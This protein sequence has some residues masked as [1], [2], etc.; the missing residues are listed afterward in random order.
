M[1]SSRF[2]F[3][4]LTAVAAFA[5]GFGTLF[6]AAWLLAPLGLAT[7]F[8][9]IFY[10]ASRTRSVLVSGFLVGFAAGGAGVWWMW[11]M[12]PINAPAGIA[13]LTQFIVAG[14]VWGM[15]ALLAGLTTMLTAL[16]LYIVRRNTFIAPLAGIVWVLQEEARMWAYAFFSYSPESL[17]GPHFSQTAIGYTLA[18]NGYLLQLAHFGGIGAL[19]FTAAAL[20]ASTAT[21]L[22]AVIHH[23]VRTP[24]RIA[25]GLSLAIA[26][27]PLAVNSITHP[28]P[29]MR[30]ALISLAGVPDAPRMVKRLHEAAS[31]SPDMVI[32]PESDTF[33]YFFP[34]SQE[35][36]NILS[37]LFP[38]KEGL[39]VSAGYENT[40]TGLQSTLSY[41]DSEGRRVSSY[42]K[43]FLMPQGEY[44][45]LAALPLFS[46]AGDPKMSE[47]VKDAGHR[48][49]RGNGLVTVPFGGAIIGGLICSELLSPHLYKELAVRYGANMLVNL[50][51]PSWF[52]GS[53]SYFDKTVEIAKVQ[54]VENSAPILVANNGSP[55]FAL[56][57]NGILLKSG[58]WG[59]DEILVVDIGR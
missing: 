49:T 33:E 48:L 12:L 11:D 28:L 1:T 2:R 24:T 26:L 18:E 3:L 45:P 17:F 5:I 56:D 4:F 30:I 31:S 58:T 50:A 57:E 43:M 53:R 54:A 10:E 14:S 21:L 35:R 9:V 41:T 19:N 46:V 7:F 51:N 38:E 13:P 20:A 15:T 47:Y 34:D 55:S 37:A 29:P 52:H 32:I 39:V 59:E 23:S 22:F 8:Y 44:Y 6:P 27:A 16:L 25:L 42:Q 40:G 36:K